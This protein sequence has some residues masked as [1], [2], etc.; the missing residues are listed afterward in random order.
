MH[1]VTVQPRVH[2][3]SPVS[4]TH[5]CFTY[6]IND[7]EAWTTLVAGELCRVLVVA[8]WIVHCMCIVYLITL[9]INKEVKECLWWIVVVN[10]FEAHAFSFYF[11]VYHFLVFCLH[12]PIHIS[13]SI[14]H[15]SQLIS[16]FK[17]VQKVTQVKVY[18]F[19]LRK[20]DYHLYLCTTC[21]TPTGW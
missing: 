15:N 1:L 21:S 17:N 8:G 16:M 4:C 14:M 2:L 3:W 6:H 5:K 11:L 10:H 18:S 12:S 19:P 7:V 13:Q 20:S 9:D